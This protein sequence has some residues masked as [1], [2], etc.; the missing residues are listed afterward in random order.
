MNIDQGMDKEWEFIVRDKTT[1]VAEDISTAEIT[2]SVKRIKS[3]IGT[4]ILRQ[5]T[6][7]KGESSTEITFTTDG[8]DGKFKMNLVPANT[9]DLN[10]Y[11]YFYS[12]LVVLSTKKKIPLSGIFNI[13]DHSI[14]L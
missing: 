4:D 1:K 13:N 9:S 11:R 6:A 3:Q 7:A 2:F 10:T 5:N 12:I 8:T 14:V